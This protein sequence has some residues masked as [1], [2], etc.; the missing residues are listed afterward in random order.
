M[1]EALGNSLYEY[2]IILEEEERIKQQKRNERANRKNK[3]RDKTLNPEPKP[4]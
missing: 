1:G 2:L 4:I 3:N